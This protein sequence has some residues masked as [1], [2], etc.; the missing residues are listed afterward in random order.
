MLIIITSL[1]NNTTVSR[2]VNEDR[3]E[4]RVI[5]LIRYLGSCGG[6]GSK[7]KP[8]SGNFTKNN[9]IS[10]LTSKKVAKTAIKARMVL[11]DGEVVEETCKLHI[12]TCIYRVRYMIQLPPITA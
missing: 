5:G 6:D 10:S 7:P 9:F 3:A 8:G 12:G 11:V 2:I 4:M 1:N